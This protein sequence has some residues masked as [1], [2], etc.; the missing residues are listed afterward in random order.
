MNLYSTVGEKVQEALT[1]TLTRIG[2]TDPLVIFKHQNGPEPDKTYCA[3]YIIRLQ[4]TGRATKSL[5]L[6]DVTGDYSVGRHYSQ[7]HFRATLQLTFVGKNSGDMAHDLKQAM[8][9]SLLAREDLL[10]QDLS[11]LDCTDIRSNPQLRETRWVE[12]FNFDI[13]LGYSVQHTE[14]LTWVEYITI[15]GEQFPAP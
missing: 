10:K 8:N 1:N 5:F 7:Q 12:S 14:D 9:N 6:E 11:F 2:Y 13:N 15:N 4:D 3:I